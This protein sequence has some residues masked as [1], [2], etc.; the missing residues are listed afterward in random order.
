VVKVRKECEHLQIYFKP[1]MIGYRCHNCGNIVDVNGH[2]KKQQPNGNWVN[3]ENLDKIKFPCFCSFMHGDRKCYG[4]I[5]KS[6]V[7]SSIVYEVSDITRQINGEPGQMFSVI[8]TSDTL[9]NLIKYHD[10]KIKK[11]KIIIFEEE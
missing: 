10:I 8:Y 2:I 7:N 11:G 6:Y 1:G 4:E 5:N 3:G 9:V